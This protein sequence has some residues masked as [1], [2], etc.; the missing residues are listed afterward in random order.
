MGMPPESA[1]LKRWRTRTPVLIIGSH[2]WNTPYN[3]DGHIIAGHEQQPRVLKAAHSDRCA[4]RCMRG[5][6][7]REVVHPWTRN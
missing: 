5:R 3:D 6:T 1:A 4:W 2:A 7:F